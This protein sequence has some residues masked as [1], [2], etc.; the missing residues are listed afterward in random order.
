MLKPLGILCSAAILTLTASAAVPTRPQID[1]TNYVIHADIDPATNKLTAT[2]V[3][4]FVALDDLPQ[5]VF[6]LNNGLAVTKVTDAKGAI[7]PS[8][9]SSTDSTIRLTPA[10]PVAKGTTATYT[11]TYAGALTLDTSPVDGIKL[12]AIADPISILLYAGRWFP[13][14][15]PGLFTDRFTAETHITVPNAER[16]VGSGFKSQAPAG[17]DRTEYV[18][19]WTRSGFPGTIVAGKFLAPFS[20]PGIPNIKVFT[21]EATKDKRSDFANQ[22]A[23]EFEFFSSTFGPAETGNLNVV[24]LPAD[25]VSAA[26]APEVVAIRPTAA[27]RASSPTPS[28]ASGGAIRSRRSRSTTPGSPTG[29]R[30]TPS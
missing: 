29:S 12:A 10:A 25:A 6:G 21:T 14:S 11:F 8:E 13:I 30:A 22:A 4:S 2:A 24:E 23:R 18:F 20:P 28:R 19:N 7:I 26:W 15:M 27:T 3:V 9:R 1:V 5:L 16:V 17:G